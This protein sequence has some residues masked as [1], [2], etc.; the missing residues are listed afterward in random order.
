[1]KIRETLFDKALVLEPDGRE[2]QRGRVTMFSPDDLGKAIPG[3][4]LKEQR[5]YSIPKPHTFFGIHFQEDPYPQA[6]LISVLHGKGMDFV[7]DLR[8]ESSTFCQW[9]ALEL[10]DDQPLAVYIPAGFGHAF[11]SLEADTVQFFAAD[12]HFFTG[13]ARS[14]SYMDPDIRLELPC[15]DLI[16]SDQDRLA[17]FLKYLD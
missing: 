15:K 5:I 17:P 14:V 8:R 2:D 3:F 12:E 7:V 13:F 10:N 4:V 16:L 11:L 1:M 6:K 9:K